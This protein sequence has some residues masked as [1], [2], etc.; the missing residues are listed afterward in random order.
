MVEQDRAPILVIETP[1]LAPPPGY[2]NV[3]T[4]AGSRLVFVAGQAAYDGAGNLVGDGD[5]T[6]Q[7]RQVFVNLDA[8]LRAAGCSAANLVKMTVFLRD[9]RH[10]QIYRESRDK[11]LSSVSP[12]SRPAVTLVEV[13]RLF[14]DELLIEI[15]AIA[16]C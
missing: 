8:A 14:S 4:A 16:S 2:S 13:S 3:V 15:E 10:L 9:M 6:A 5:I 1:A 12:P 7:T 11:F